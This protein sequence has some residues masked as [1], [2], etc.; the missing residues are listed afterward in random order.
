MHEVLAGVSYDMLRLYVDLNLRLT[1][2]AGLDGS[3]KVHFWIKPAGLGKF[4]S[5]G[6]TTRRRAN[7]RG[8]SQHLER[9]PDPCVVKQAGGAVAGYAGRAV[10]RAVHEEGA[11]DR[12]CGQI[13]RGRS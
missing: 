12:R 7:V 11:G 10:E 9:R 2:V 8:Q 5:N 13:L 6:K 3:A 4:P 1:K